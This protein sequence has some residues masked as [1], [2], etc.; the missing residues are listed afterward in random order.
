MSVGPARALG[1]VTVVSLLSVTVVACTGSGEPGAAMVGASIEGGEVDTGD[2]AVGLLVYADGNSCTATL[3]APDVLLTAGHCVLQALDGFYTE[4]GSSSL[5]PG[6]TRHPVAAKVAHPQ[7]RADAID[8]PNVTPDVALVRLQA[9]IAGVTPIAFARATDRLPQ[10]RD[11]VV[12]VG[13]GVHH[14]PGSQDFE[15]DPGAVKRRATERVLDTP[16]AS[17]HVERV[18]GIVN[19]GDSGGPLVFG[20]T[21][22]GTASCITSDFPTDYTAYYGRVDV[23]APWIAATLA[24]WGHGS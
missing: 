16:A 6:M 12:A 23:A 19:H 5:I 14:T 1:R 2:P 20:Q 11:E 3:I 21:I 24:S 4:G 8:C 9:P 10:A 22:F 18:T 13:Y 15:G 7:Y 17:V